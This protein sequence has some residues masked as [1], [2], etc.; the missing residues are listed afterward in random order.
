MPIITRTSTNKQAVSRSDSYRDIDL[1]L[2]AQLLMGSGIVGG[3]SISYP[4][5]DPDGEEMLVSYG[6]FRD[7]RTGRGGDHVTFVQS[8]MNCNQKVAVAMLR[9]YK[10]T[11]GSENR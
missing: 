7:L 6:G 9:V 10:L 11:H 3:T 1:R 4:S 5:F 8:Q 2:I